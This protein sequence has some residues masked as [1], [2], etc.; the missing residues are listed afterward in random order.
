MTPRL[1]QT[2]RIVDTFFGAY[3]FSPAKAIRGLRGTPAF[4]SDRRTFKKLL[5]RRTDWTFGATL[6]IL[7]ERQTQSGS[8]RGHYF[9]QD[10]RVAQ[11]IHQVNPRRHID[12]GSRIDGFVAHV[13][14]FRE[15]EVVD[16]R[17][18]DTA[19][20]NIKFLRMD[21]MD[22]P[23]P[24]QIA[25]CDSLSCL[26]VLEHFGLGRYGDRIDPDGY[27]AGFANLVTM[28]EPGGVLYFSVPMGRQRIEFNAHRIFGL[29]HL[30][31]MFDAYALELLNYSYVDDHDNLVEDVAISPEAILTANG[32]RYGCG[33][34]ELRKPV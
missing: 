18:L 9:H 22:T 33:I 10:L 34:F 31:E 20:P 8:A 1:R 28:L 13:A 15:I 32:L 24:D 29:Q 14:A 5:G 25:I 17:P 3:G 19:I 21:L 30:L 6:P 11:R 16:I 7:D 26:H 27:K 2:A 12:V 4:L 23:G